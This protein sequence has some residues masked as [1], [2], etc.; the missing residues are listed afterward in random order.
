[1]REFGLSWNQTLPNG[2]LLVSN[3]VKLL[4]SVSAVK[5]S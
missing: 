1:R 4:I 2:G 5:E 3:D